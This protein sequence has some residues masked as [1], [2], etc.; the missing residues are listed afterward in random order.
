ME[1]ECTLRHLPCQSELAEGQRVGCEVAKNCTKRNPD[2]KKTDNKGKAICYER[3]GIRRSKT[4]KGRTESFGP[5][6]RNLRICY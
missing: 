2:G 6:R 5:T 4:K 1:P 3:D